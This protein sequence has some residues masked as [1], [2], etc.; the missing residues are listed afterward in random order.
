MSGYFG[1]SY[2]GELEYGL[3]AP[4]RPKHFQPAP[5]VVQARSSLSPTG[6]WNDADR[7]ASVVATCKVPGKCPS[8]QRF[9]KRAR[10]LRGR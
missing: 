8:C 1:P 10:D 9:D 2:L 5:I 6:L 7:L 3:L 4:P